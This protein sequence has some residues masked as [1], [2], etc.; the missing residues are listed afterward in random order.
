MTAAPGRN[1]PR[2]SRRG[3]TGLAGELI[4]LAGVVTTVAVLL[5]GLVAWHTL[6]R[7]AEAQERDQL[8]RQATV[9]SRVPALSTLLYEGEQR[10][11]GA[12]GVQIAVLDASGVVSGPAAP[13]L[14]TAQR[15]VLL[16]GR[17]LSATGELRG[18]TVLVEGRPAR[19]GRAVVLTKPL[20]DVDRAAA[21]MRRNLL[22]PL[23][24]GLAGAAV[25]GVTLARR[26]AR[27]LGRAADTA[28]RLAEGE[29][30]VA[31]AAAASG[32]VEVVQLERSLAVLDAA[33][34]RGEERQ[35]EF[36]LSISHEIRTPLTSVLGYAEALTDDVVPASRL[37]EVGRILRAEAQRL[38]RFLGDLLDLARLEA[39]D[40]RLDLAPVDLDLLVRE[41]AT[42]WRG[43]CARHDVVFRLEHPGT[44]V[45][46]S[47][48]GFRVRQLM[49]CLLANALRITPA[50]RP[51][52]LAL[53]AAEGAVEVQVR[54]G[55]P[56]LTEDDVAVAFER[57]V[58]HERYRG[59]RPVG[60]G[61]G[62]AIA[63]RLASRLGGTLT[64]RAHGP[65]GG[66][67]FT[68]RLPA[69]GRDG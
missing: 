46:L 28:S 33:L 35:R 9:L 2:R 17:A 49:D 32:P 1:R 57:G 24:A 65:E 50:G 51:V 36:L 30:G 47:T 6:R 25:A 67:A 59:L 3:R 16:S 8:S 11:A 5:T 40:F 54:D 39:D 64:A 13:V 69:T 43:R 27:P 68:L 29:R 41:A 44:A 37:P 18:S 4:L 63:H 34:A 48:D 38:D 66:A 23:G 42:S 14:D 10:L 53:R 61:L 20:T 52:V 26:I 62:L 58:L 22:L 19:R 45:M 60:S 15:D 56:G 21:R 31:G 55:G 7:A 12:N